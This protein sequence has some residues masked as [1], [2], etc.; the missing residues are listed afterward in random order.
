M[1]PTGGNRQLAP[2]EI[3]LI[4]WWIQ[5][6]ARFDQPLSNAPA[7]MVPTMKKVID[8]A[9]TRRNS[10]VGCN[11]RTQSCCCRWW[12]TQA[13]KDFGVN[14]LPFPRDPMP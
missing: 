7:N 13:V 2:D 1:P 8:V 6:G 10:R 9:E 14:V 4:E 5:S 12:R 3:R 11:W